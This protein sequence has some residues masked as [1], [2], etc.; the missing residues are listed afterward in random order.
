ML[1]GP[2]DETRDLETAEAIKLNSKN[3]GEKI[4]VLLS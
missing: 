2:K 1:W 3:G 4:V